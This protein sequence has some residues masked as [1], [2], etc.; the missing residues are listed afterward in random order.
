[1]AVDDKVR[2]IDVGGA[3]WHD[4]DTRR[5]LHHAEQDASWRVLRSVN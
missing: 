2:G 3:R 5:I 1:M 4:I